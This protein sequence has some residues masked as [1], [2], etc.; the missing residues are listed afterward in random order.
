MATD[1]EKLRILI[2]DPADGS[3]LLSDDDLT[4]I[5]EIESSI[6]LRLC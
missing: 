1:I 5:L 3:E 2:Q 4:A 6:E